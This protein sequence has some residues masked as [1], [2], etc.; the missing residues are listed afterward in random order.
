MSPESPLSSAFIVVAMLAFDKIRSC[1][2]ASVKARKAVG[3]CGQRQG[4]R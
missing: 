1:A 4:G 3:M 2:V